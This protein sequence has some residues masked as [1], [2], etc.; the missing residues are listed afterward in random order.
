MA[1]PGP[2]R[3]FLRRIGAWL[4][5][6][7]TARADALELAVAAIRKSADDAEREGEVKK[8]RRKRNRATLLEL[9]AQQLREED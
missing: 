2:A 8:A 5:Q 7:R 9:R 3:I 4:S 6:N 1:A